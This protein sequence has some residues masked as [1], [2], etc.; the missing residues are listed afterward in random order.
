MKMTVTIRLEEEVNEKLAKLSYFS[1]KTK[2]DLITEALNLLFKD[3]PVGDG[4]TLD[5]IAGR[6]KK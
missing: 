2:G 5:E 4:L 3:V 6:Q 1:G